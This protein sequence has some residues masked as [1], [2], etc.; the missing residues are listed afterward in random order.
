MGFDHFA[1]LFLSS[2]PSFLLSLSSSA[3]LTWKPK[4][5]EKKGKNERKNKEEKEGGREKGKKQWKN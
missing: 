2:F 5:E 3:S 1:L 4:K